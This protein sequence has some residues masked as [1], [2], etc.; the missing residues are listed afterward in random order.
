MNLLVRRGVSYARCNWSR[1]VGDCPS[2][3]CLAALQLRRYQPWFTCMECGETGEIVWPARAEDVERLLSMRPDPN[4][5]N[6]EPG[7]TLNDLLLE[8]MQHGVLSHA[9]VAAPP[10]PLL[11]IVDDAIIVDVLPRLG[12]YEIGA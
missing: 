6:W 10:G 12:R 9:A 3:F 7:E 4:T 2:P 1:W 11:S 5:R 8:N